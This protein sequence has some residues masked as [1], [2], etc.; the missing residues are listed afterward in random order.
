MVTLTR[1]LLEVFIVSKTLEHCTIF[2]YTLQII[3]ALLLQRAYT[4][5]GPEKGK[6]IAHGKS[7][8]INKYDGRNCKPHSFTPLPLHDRDTKVFS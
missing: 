2:A 3:I 8:R 5:F 7:S 6:E 4:P 1:I